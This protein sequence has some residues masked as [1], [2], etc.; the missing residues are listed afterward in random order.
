MQSNDEVVEWNV[1]DGLMLG[2]VIVC[3]HDS[4]SDEHPCTPGLGCDGQR[5]LNMPYRTLDDLFIRGDGST[6]D[7]SGEPQPD[8]ANQ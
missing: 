8:G 6:F 1:E 4:C 5:T 3:N 2:A 7:L